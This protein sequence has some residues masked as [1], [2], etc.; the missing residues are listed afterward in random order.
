MLSISEHETLEEASNE[1]LAF[2]LAP[3]NWI[4]LGQLDARP[5]ERPGQNAAYQRRVGSLRI[6]AS[7]DVTPRLDV[8]LRVAFRAPGLTPTRAADHLVE[9]LA[10][11]IPLTPNSEW[12][13]HVDD[14]DW[15]HFIRRYTSGAL[16]A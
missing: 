4:A 16:Q 7:I 9:F 15:V 10:D 13:V 2:V 14:R 8:F 3:Q 6:C 5:H 1:L 12:Q 11:S